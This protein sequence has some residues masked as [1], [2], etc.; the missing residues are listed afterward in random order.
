MQILRLEA[1][2]GRPLT[3]L[4]LGAHAD[5]LEIGCGATILQLLAARRSA[6]VTWV[7]CSGG[8]TRLREA[9]SAAARFLAGAAEAKTV[10]LEARDGY[11][12]W[13]GGALKQSIESLKGVAPDVIFTHRLEDRHQDHRVV[14]ELTWNTFRDHLILEYEI[15]KFE[16]DLG[17]PNCFVPIT[18]QQLDAKCEHLMAAYRSQRDKPWFTAETFRGLARLRGVECRSPTGYAE[19]F[20]ARKMTLDV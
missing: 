4:C 9:R 6:V 15:P 2:E 19:A 1:D 17:H 18:R 16:G 12:P 20:H 11:F 7:I 10:L 5:D 3:V 14:A 13:D 8:E